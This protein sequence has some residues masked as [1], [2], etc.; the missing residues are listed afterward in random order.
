MLYHKLLLPLHKAGYI[1]AVGNRGDSW[2]GVIKRSFST[3]FLSK[4][5]A[6]KH[7]WFLQQFLNNDQKNAKT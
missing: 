1:R 7:V 5:N 2:H 4:S 3:G 6:E